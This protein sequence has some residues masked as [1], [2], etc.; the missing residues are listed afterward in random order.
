MQ[1]KYTTSLQV[2][3]KSEAEEKVER[4]L[5][6]KDEVDKM[7][8]WIKTVIQKIYKEILEVSLVVKATMEE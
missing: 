2:K 4:E 8:Q 3:E 1:E 5:K 6:E 7:A